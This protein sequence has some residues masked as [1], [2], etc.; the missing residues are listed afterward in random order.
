MGKGLSSRDIKNLSLGLARPRFESSYLEDA[1]FLDNAF[2]RF[3]VFSL[4]CK[5]G[6]ECAQQPAP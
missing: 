4:I 2:Y 1:F 5:I 6:I 3:E